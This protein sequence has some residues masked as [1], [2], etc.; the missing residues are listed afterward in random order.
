MST[1]RQ[2]ERPRFPPDLSGQID[3][4]AT[5][6]HAHF[7]S[8]PVRFLSAARG[9]EAAYVARLEWSRAELDAGP[10][11]VVMLERSGELVC[12]SLP[13][14]PLAAD[15]ATPCADA[16]NEADAGRLLACAAALLHAHFQPAP[17]RF[18]WWADGEEV[19]YLAGFEWPR[20]EMGT[21]PRVVVMRASKGY[22]VCMSLPGRLLDV[23]PSTVNLD[24][25][26]DDELELASRRR[27]GQQQRDAQR[28]HDAERREAGYPMARGVTDWRRP[29]WHGPEIGANAPAPAWARGWRN[30]EG[31]T[32]AEAL[33]EFIRVHRRLLPCAVEDAAAM[34]AA[35]LDVAG[36]FR[37]GDQ[38]G[39]GGAYVLT[40]ATLAAFVAEQGISA[41]TP[42]ELHTA[43][44]ELVETGHLAPRVEVNSLPSL[45]LVWCYVVAAEVAELR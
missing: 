34:E 28:R 38:E 12:T 5:V 35:R 4:G 8:A 42:A 14:Q 41:V 30:G 2:P 19:A 23:D 6:Q 27:S 17:L 36:F 33:G 32:L 40:L 21:G 31:K 45:G 7:Q 29:A 1:S 39:R 10:R 13:G 3:R 26:G 11:V 16:C 9:P 15:P 20:A 18:T 43:C 44:A 25:C 22:P 24:T 37:P